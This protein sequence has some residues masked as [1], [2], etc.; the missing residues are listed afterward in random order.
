M[1]TYSSAKVVI[2]HIPEAVWLS[3]NTEYGTLT[4]LLPM[5]INEKTA[6]GFP[7]TFHT[8][9]QILHFLFP[10]IMEKFKEVLLCSN[11]PYLPP[12]KHSYLFSQSFNN[13]YQNIIPFS[14]NTC[15]SNIIGDFPFFYGAFGVYKCDFF[16]YRII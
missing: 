13:F 5:S 1:N 11:S 7:L 2:F 4:F 15:F 6:F 3:T 8:P 10:S 16:F 9:F 12:C 14:N